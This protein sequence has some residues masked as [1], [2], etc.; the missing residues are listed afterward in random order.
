MAIYA[1]TETQGFIHIDE[2][3]L[4]GLY[5]KLTNTSNEDQDITG[6]TIKNINAGESGTAQSF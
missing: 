4:D 1:R 2:L 5:V 3:D 6:C